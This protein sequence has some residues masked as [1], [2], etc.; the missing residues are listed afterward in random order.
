MRGTVGVLLEIALNL[1]INLNLERIDIS[2]TFESSYLAMWLCL[3]IYSRLLLCLSVKFYDFIPIDLR[4]KYFVRLEL[5]Y[6]FLLLD[7]S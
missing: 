5:S 6:S 4:Q 7:F 3:S 1:N 2:K